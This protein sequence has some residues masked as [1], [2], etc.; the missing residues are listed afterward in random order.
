MVLLALELNAAAKTMRLRV[1]DVAAVPVGSGKDGTFSIVKPTNAPAQ[2]WEYRL[3]EASEQ[4]VA[5]SLYE[6][7]R[8][9]QE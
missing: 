6:S 5:L 7:A 4:P 8:A 3:K 1:Y 2:P 9:R